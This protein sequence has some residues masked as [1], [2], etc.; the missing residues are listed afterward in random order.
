M[1]EWGGR[2]GWKCGEGDGEEEG[3]GNI[4]FE[5]LV[6][7]HV[8]VENSRLED[9]SQCAASGRL[10]HAQPLQPSVDGI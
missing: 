9:C 4:P 2:K 1:R 8:K 6:E 7:V 3:G 5:V 10:L